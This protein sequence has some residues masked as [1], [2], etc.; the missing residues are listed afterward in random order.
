MIWVIREACRKWLQFSKCSMGLIHGEQLALIRTPFILVFICITFHK[1]AKVIHMLL[2]SWMKLSWAWSYSKVVL[3]FNF[4]W[5][6]YHISQF[7]LLILH[8]HVNH[9]H[10]QHCHYH[11]CCHCQ[12]HHLAYLLCI[13]NEFTNTAIQSFIERKQE[14]LDSGLH[15]VAYF[16]T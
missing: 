12:L 8:H 5:R 16:L 15:A 1:L 10:Q 11:D 13:C 9:P 7:L 6:L 14:A 2:F 4:T 3:M